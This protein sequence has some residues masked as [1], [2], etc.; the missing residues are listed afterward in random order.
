MQKVG[1]DPTRKVL[2]VIKEFNLYTQ[3]GSTKECYMVRD[4]PVVWWLRIYLLC[5]AGDVGPILCWEN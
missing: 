4:F 1:S 3:E 5:R 2:N